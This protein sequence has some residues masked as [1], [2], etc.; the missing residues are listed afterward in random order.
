MRP[1]F[2]D[3]GQVCLSAYKRSRLRSFSKRFRLCT[4]VFSEYECVSRCKSGFEC[5]RVFRALASGFE[6]VKLC[7]SVFECVQVSCVHVAMPYRVV[8]FVSLWFERV[9]SANGC[10]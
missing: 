9:S 4:N 7:T 10:F 3:C 6:C 5:V 2:Y 8:H 1:S